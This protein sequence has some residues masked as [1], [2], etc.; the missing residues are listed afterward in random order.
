MDLLLRQRAAGAVEIMDLPDCDPQALDNTYRQFA[1]INRVLSGW[2]RLYLR[3]VRPFLADGSRPATLLDIGS[4]G[5]DLALMLARWAARD[6]LTL[7][8]TGIDPDPRAAAFAARRTPVSGVAFRQA[9]SSDLVR[10]G[11][12]YDFVI[13]NHVL[14]HLAA[15]QLQELLAHSEILAG[16]AALHNDLRRSPAAYALFS[17]AALPFRR[18]FI[19][20]DGLTSI[21]RSYTA[22][23]LGAI[24]PPGWTVRAGSVFHQVLAYGGN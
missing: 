3:E 22:R 12:Q 9:H 11:R 8:V 4:G 14:H 10:E 5:G 16:H 21:R 15:G 2:R 1:L 17:A 20:A 19:R 7:H 6:Q 13:S 23:E 24:A 18:S